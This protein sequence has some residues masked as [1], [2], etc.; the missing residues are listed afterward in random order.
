MNVNVLSDQLREF[1]AWRRGADGPQPNPTEIGELIDS[2]ADRLEVLER[3][4]QEFFDRWH[5]CRRKL[6]AIER[7]CK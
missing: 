3:E 6:E 2:A 1:N 7:D 5:E 4:S